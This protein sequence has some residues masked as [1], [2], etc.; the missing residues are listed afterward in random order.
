MLRYT[1]IACLVEV[2][3]SILTS[4]A[5]PTN[6]A[7]FKHQSFSKIQRN[8]LKKYKIYH[9]VTKALGLQYEK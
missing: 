9:S 3:N 4:D 6:I 8:M 5:L 7:S 1:Y 2:R